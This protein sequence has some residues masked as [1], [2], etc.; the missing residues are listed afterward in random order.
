M[1]DTKNMDNLQEQKRIVQEIKNSGFAF[2]EAQQNMKGDYTDEQ[3][4]SS[5]ENSQLIIKLLGH[6]DIISHNLQEII[7]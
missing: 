4:K 7:N 2:L 6:A 1:T 5:K 3:W